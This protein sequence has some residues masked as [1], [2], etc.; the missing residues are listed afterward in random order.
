[1]IIHDQWGSTFT[2]L[3]KSRY[4]SLLLLGMVSIPIFI[5]IIVHGFIIANNLRAIA[6]LKE[7]EV[8][9]LDTV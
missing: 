5:S 2:T 1:M 9:S 3:I 8:P 4:S 6:K 7:S